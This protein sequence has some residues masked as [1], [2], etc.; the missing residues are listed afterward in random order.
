MPGEIA[1]TA[2]TR[3]AAAAASS[4]TSGTSRSARAAGVRAR[5]GRPPT[6][7][8]ARSPTT[9]SVTAGTLAVRAVRRSSPP[10]DPSPSAPPRPRASRTPRGPLVL[11]GVLLIAANLRPPITAVGPLVPVIR[12]DTGLSAAGAGLLTTLPLLAFAAASPLASPAARRVGVERMLWLGLVLIGVG[13]LVRSAG[14]VG[15]MFAG[16]AVLGVGIAAGNVLL[17]GIV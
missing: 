12:A 4:I 15:A 5:D 16:T 1:T 2:T 3:S 9:R 11:A 13:T 14:S 17:P 7:G 6:P 10:R 8:A